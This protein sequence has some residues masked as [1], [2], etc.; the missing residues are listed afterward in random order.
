MLSFR[1]APLGAGGIHTPD[2]GYRFRVRGFA[3]PRNDGENALPSRRSPHAR[4]THRQQ[5][6]QHHPGHQLQ[7][8]GGLHPPAQD[9]F[10]EWQG[11]VEEQRLVAVPEEFGNLG[12]KY[13]VIDAKIS[14]ASTTKIAAPPG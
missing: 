1:D 13:T 5:R 9:L 7:R 12:P 8:R 2:R 11:R 14:E 3:A 4:N 10:G 6:Q